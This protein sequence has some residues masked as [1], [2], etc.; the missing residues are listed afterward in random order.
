MEEGNILY[1]ASHAGVMKMYILIHT[2]LA[3]VASI[4]ARPSSPL[5]SFDCLYRDSLYSHLCLL[6]PLREHVCFFTVN[7][8]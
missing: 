5:A 3:T 8:T 4:R 7:N 1:I 2:F 6:P